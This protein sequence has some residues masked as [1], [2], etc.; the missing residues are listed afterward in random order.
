MA[1]PARIS[2]DSRRIPALG[3]GDPMELRPVVAAEAPCKACGAPTFLF[4]VVDFSRSTRTGL[5]RADVV[6]GVPIYYRRCGA[7]GLIF[8]D[9]FD[10]W[11]D[12][13]FLTHIYNEGY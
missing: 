12:A 4:G 10:G 13:D 8:T 2:Q 9:A 5:A 3:E 7:C 11:S 6:V 1:I